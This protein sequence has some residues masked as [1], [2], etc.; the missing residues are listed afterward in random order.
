MVSSPINYVRIKA[1]LYLENNFL[2]GPFF[3][4]RLLFNAIFMVSLTVPRVRIKADLSLENSY[5]KTLFRDG[6]I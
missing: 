2:R 3:S 5:L 4:D 1:D 6:L